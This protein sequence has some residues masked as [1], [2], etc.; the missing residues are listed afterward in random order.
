M[1]AAK[2]AVR[3]RVLAYFRLAREMPWMTFMTSSHAAAALVG[4]L[5]MAPSAAFA[6]DPPPNAGAQGGET[7]QDPAKAQPAPDTEPDPKSKIVWF[8][9][10]AGVSSVN[11]NTFTTNFDQF[12]VGFIPQSGIGPSIG[13]AAGFRLVFLTLG[14][15]GRAARFS[16]SGPVQEWSMASIDAEVGVRVPLHRLEPHLTLASGYT[17]FGGF[18]D[19]L[20]GV[21]QGLRV[22]GINARLG[23]GVDYF[24]SRYVSVGGLASGEL[25]MLTRPGVP[26]KE[27][28][29][30]PTSQTLDAAAIRFLEAQGS[31]YGTALALTGG[32]KA[33]F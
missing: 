31:S 2:S 18:G 29:A 11:L 6:Q 1:H 33:H 30:L 22:N 4:A 32:L 25:L 13:G 10:E 19:A 5:L 23:L 16:G 3:A 7:K 14:A 26:V 28:A 20:Q 15:R 21:Q 24:L 8:D 12:S 27:V 9:V 17:T